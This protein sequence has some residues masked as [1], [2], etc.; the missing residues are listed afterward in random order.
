MSTDRVLSELDL[1]DVKILSG[2][3]LQSGL[4]NGDFLLALMLLY[5]VSPWNQAYVG[6]IRVVYD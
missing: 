2:F 3:L 1:L 6:N 4:T 5:A